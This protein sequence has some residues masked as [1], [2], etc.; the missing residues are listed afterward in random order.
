LFHDILGLGY[1]PRPITAHDYD[2][3]CLNRTIER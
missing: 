1:P 3:V 2:G